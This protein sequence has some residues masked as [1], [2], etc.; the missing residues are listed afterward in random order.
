MPEQTPVK[1]ITQKGPVLIECVIPEDDKV[2]PM[3]PA[4]EAISEA[5]DETDLK[6]KENE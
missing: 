6:K 1:A 3:V 5:F 4:G 2:F